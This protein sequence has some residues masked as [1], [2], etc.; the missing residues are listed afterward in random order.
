LVNEIGFCTKIKWFRIRRKY[1][2]DCVDIS[3]DYT[4]GYGY[5]VEAEVIIDNDKN[6]Q[7]AKEKVYALFNKLNV[8]VTPE[9][10]FTKKYNDY[11]MNWSKYTKNINE[12]EFLKSSLNLAF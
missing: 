9:A 5:I 11:K 3:L 12:D 4:V 8:K 7:N 2:L 6:L 10:I 1:L